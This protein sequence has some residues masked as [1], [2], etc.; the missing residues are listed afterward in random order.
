MEI[1]AW[2]PVRLIT[3]PRLVQKVF[4]QNK[5]RSKQIL[6]KNVSLKND[7]SVLCILLLDHYASCSYGSHSILLISVTLVLVTVD[8]SVSRGYGSPCIL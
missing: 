7:H 4:R 5:F 8:H 1:F 2:S 6:T 3:Y